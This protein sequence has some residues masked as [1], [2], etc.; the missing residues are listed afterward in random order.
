MSLLLIWLENV[1]ARARARVW[2][3]KVWPGVLAM[4]LGGVLIYGAGFAVTDAVHNAAH[5]GR[6]SASFPCH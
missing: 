3:E 4:L 2:Q 6:H 5:D 1:D